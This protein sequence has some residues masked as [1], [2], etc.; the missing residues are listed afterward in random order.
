MKRIIAGS[1][2]LAASACPAWAASCA[3]GFPIVEEMSKTLDLSE[4]EKANVHALVAKAR[5][6]ERLGHQKNCKLILSGAIRFFLI[7]TVLD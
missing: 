4:A 5:I 2:L 3:E 7:K 1:F 6:E